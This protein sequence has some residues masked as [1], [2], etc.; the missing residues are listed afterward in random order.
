MPLR[1]ERR[2]LGFAC[3]SAQNL[4]LRQIHDASTLLLLTR[5]YLPD[6]RRSSCVA[7]CRGVAG[8]RVGTRLTGINAEHLL[9]CLA[10][11]LHMDPGWGMGVVARVAGSPRAR[12]RGVA[13]NGRSRR[14][15]GAS[16]RGKR[17]RFPKAPH[18][19]TACENFVPLSTSLLPLRLS[20]VVSTVEGV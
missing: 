12:S 7:R 11:G 1:G 8:K 6:H 2:S 9:R 15:S 5:S 16:V 18:E 14:W 4:A 13:P 20:D 3:A 17:S 10:H 19:K